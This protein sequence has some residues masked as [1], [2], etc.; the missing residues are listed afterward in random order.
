[1]TGPQA[2]TSEAVQEVIDLLNTL[3]ATQPQHHRR[4]QQ[5]AQALQVESR[6]RADALRQYEQEW[7]KLRERAE[8]ER[9]RADAAEQ[10]VRRLQAQLEPLQEQVR[11]MAALQG[12][13]EQV[14]A[15]EAQVETAR[16]EVQLQPE[17]VALK[18]QLDAFRNKIYRPRFWTAAFAEAF[19]ESL[20]AMDQAHRPL[21]VGSAEGVQAAFRA[22]HRDMEAGLDLFITS[23]FDPDMAEGLRRDLI[24]QWVYLRWL[25]LTDDLGRP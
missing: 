11:A 9:R 4:G 2:G 25:E 18:G 17:F 20:A 3:T 14:R 8:T 22:W 19:A 1:M 15:L 24:C 16:A 5:V 23:G 6:Q 12:L 21:E 10:E 7:K 13:P